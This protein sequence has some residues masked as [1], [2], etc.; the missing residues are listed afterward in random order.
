ML[1]DQTAKSKNASSFKSIRKRF[2]S[3]TFSEPTYVNYDGG[4]YSSDEEDMEELFGQDIS[5]QKEDPQQEQQEQQSSQVAGDEVEITDEGANV[6]PLKTRSSKETK[7]ES[8]QDA[9]EEGERRS[10]EDILDGRAEGQSRSRNGTLRNTD[11]FFKDD[12]VE[13]KKISLTPNLLRDDG[14]PRPSTDST[15]SKDAKSRPSLDIKMEKELVVDKDKKKSKEKEKDK[16]EKDKKPS[17]IRNFFSRKDKRRTS[18]DDDGESFGKRSMDVGSEP[19]DS[20][21]PAADEAQSPE[22]TP[23]R[24]PSKLQKQQPRTEPSPAAGKNA[25]A[26]PKKPPQADIASHFAETRTNDVSNVPPVSM[27]IIDP[28]TQE[29]KEVPSNQQQSSN[30]ESTVGTLAKSL[31]PRTGSSGSTKPQK[32]VKAKARMELDESDSSEAEEAIL[33]SAAPQHLESEPP[34]AAEEKPQRP[35]LPGAFP[36]S[37]QST[38]TASSDRTVTRD[39]RQVRERLSE[40]P[41]EVSP[42]SPVSPVNASQPPGL[43]ADSPSPDLRQTDGTPKDDKEAQQTWDDTKLRAFFDAGDHVRDL[44]AVV[45]D[46]SD[47]EPAGHDHPVVNSLFREQNAKLAEITTV[48]NTLAQKLDEPRLTGLATRQHARRLARTETAL[49]GHIVIELMMTIWI[50]VLLFPLFLLGMVGD[51]EGS[52]PFVILLGVC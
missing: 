26:A 45:Y 36:Q 25:A 13:T 30:E 23:S 28:N 8:A 46:T 41:V 20:E 2:K 12:S 37:F 16:K 50:C 38:T 17:A 47:V 29:A 39:Q 33:Q 6:E 9:I 15:A 27:R 48:S 42:V 11:S 40:S 43:M 24:S 14:A 19:R 4:D 3:V 49:E 21:D 35:T 18:E 5:V 7:E 31:L 34:L 1:G 52:Y 22:K 44:L 10:S 51:R 32:T